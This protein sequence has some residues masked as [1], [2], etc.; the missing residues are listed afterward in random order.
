MSDMS[1]FA[2]DDGPDKRSG[3]LAVEPEREGRRGGRRAAKKVVLPR[4]SYVGTGQA[5]GRRR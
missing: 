3:R 2:G 4:R 5:S 1:R